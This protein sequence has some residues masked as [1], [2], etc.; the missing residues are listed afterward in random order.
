L[1]KTTGYYLK[2][3]TFSVFEVSSWLEERLLVNWESC[4]IS[5]FCNIFNDGIGPDN[6]VLTFSV[7]FPSFFNGVG[8][9]NVIVWHPDAVHTYPSLHFV[10]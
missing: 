7:I 8:V 6:Y 2:R 9:L 1:I 4:W 3:A 10:I 5:E